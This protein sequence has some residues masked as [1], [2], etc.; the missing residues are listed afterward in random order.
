MKKAIMILTAVIMAA[1]MNLGAQKPT[2]C[3]HHKEECK[4][5]E[6]CTHK[7][8]CKVDVKKCN[9]KECAPNKCDVKKCETCTGVCEKKCTPQCKAV[10]TDCKRPCADKNHGKKVK[11]TKQAKKTKN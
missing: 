11:L 2:E 7:K 6:N 1:T 10:C 4:K 9:V 5:I 3:K 8:E